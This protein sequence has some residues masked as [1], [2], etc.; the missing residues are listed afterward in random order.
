MKYTVQEK[1]DYNKSKIAKTPKLKDSA[2]CH[3]YVLGVD[4]YKKYPK[5]PE[6]DKVVVK[7]LISFSISRAI[8]GNNYYKGYACAIRDCAN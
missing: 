7:N 6:K 2:F 4:D 1:Y 5:M 3:G 8:H